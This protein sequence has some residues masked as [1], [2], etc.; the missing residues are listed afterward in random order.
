MISSFPNELISSVSKAKEII[1]EAI[2]NNTLI[3]IHGDYDADGVCATA[4]LYLTL[5][6]TLKYSNV[7]FVIPD[8]FED[9]Y[10]LSDKTLKKILDLSFNQSFL[11]ITVDSG[12]TSISQVEKI[13]E[14]GNQ[15]IITDHHHQGDLLPPADVIV[16]SDEVVGSVI[17][18]FVAL[19]L[20]NKDSQIMSLAG[21]ATV[22]DVF[23]IQGF[24]KVLVR[25]S[26]SLMKKNPPLFIKTMYRLIGRKFEDIGVYDLG[27]VI[28]P[29]I[30][31]SGRIASADLSLSLLIADEVSEIER[32]VS[33]INQINQSRQEMTQEAFEKLDLSSL[34]SKKIIIYFS[35]DLN[36]GL[37][38]LLASKIVQN[39]HKPAFAIAKNGD[40]VKG[41]ARSIKGIDVVDILKNSSDF[42]T[43]FGGHT[44][45]GGFSLR[46]SDL[47]LFTSC[48][49]KYV[50]SKYENF[51]FEK[52]ILVDCE[53]NSQ[54]ISIDLVNFLEKLEPF[55][56]SNEEP[57]FLLKDLTITEIKK[58]GTSGQHLSI[59]VKSDDKNFKCLA[60]N[61]DPKYEELYLGQN[62][63][64]IFKTRKN[65][66]N[67]RINIDLL[68]V[69][70]KT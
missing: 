16:W 51:S 27:F 13:K 8:R 41:S 42:L 32:L 2:S 56:N 25:K 68:L 61:F 47:D 31:S 52:L 7:T 28:G 58:I 10:G 57:V 63:D 43:S 1:L 14:L 38:G 30:N 44:M 66:F 4:I 65:I 53:I 37:L 6:K 50:D 23:P 39:F 62:I 3:I 11:L 33:D 64:I 19:S 36:E 9:G 60:F 17:S 40:Y 67:D 69:D 59:F 35:P 29:R 18:W 34:G 24:N 45:A 26:L 49:E 55:G 54:I 12:I 20:G 46:E 21:L 22:T 70:F 15:V 5:T 48:V